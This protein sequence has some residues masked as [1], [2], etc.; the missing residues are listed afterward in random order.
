M[1]R[2]VYL[3]RIVR[4]ARLAS[5]SS[6]TSVLR[7][8]TGTRGR[9]VPGPQPARVPFTLCG[10]GLATWRCWR[11][12]ALRP[13]QEPCDRTAT[14]F[15]LE[16]HISECLGGCVAHDKASRRL[17]EF[18][19][20]RETSI[21]HCRYSSSSAPRTLPFVGFTKC[22]RRHAIQTICSQVSSSTTSSVLMPCTL[23]PVF[24]QQYRNSVTGADMRHLRWRGPS[25]ARRSLPLLEVRRGRRRP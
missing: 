24:G 3:Y 21:S 22:N 25:A 14:G 18:P 20:R 10:A 2:P 19:R 8:V 9:A 16:I 6:L 5:G 23:W 13:A 17:I 11:Q 1:P 7:N 15:F 4:T 12:S